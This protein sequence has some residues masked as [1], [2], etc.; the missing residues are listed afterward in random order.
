M[1]DFPSPSPL[2]QSVGNKPTMVYNMY[3]GENRVQLSQS[4]SVIC[5]LHDVD[6]P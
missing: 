2:T 6:Y 4:W 1:W 3:A 5:V